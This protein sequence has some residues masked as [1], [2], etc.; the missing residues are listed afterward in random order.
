MGVAPA[1]VAR[2]LRAAVGLEERPGAL[3]QGVSDGSPAQAAG[4]AAATSSPRSATTPST[5]RP[6]YRRRWP[7]ASQAALIA[8]SIV[9]AQP[10]RPSPSP[11]GPRP[12]PQA[13]PR[14][15][16]SDAP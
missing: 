15:A 14:A 5:T 3:V 2:R 12:R 10:P 4:I 11:P 6:G 16:P 13:R 9:R 1:H 8:V 7:T